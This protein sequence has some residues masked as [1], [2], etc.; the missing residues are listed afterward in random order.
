M[1]WFYLPP[2]KDGMC[3]VAYGDEATKSIEYRAGR[4]FGE[5]DA[6]LLVGMFTRAGMTPEKMRE[7]YHRANTSPAA[8]THK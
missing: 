5:G 8:G 2:D 3:C 7:W 4:A 1:S 6:G